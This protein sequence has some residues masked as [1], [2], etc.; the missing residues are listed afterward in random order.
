MAAERL[1]T[2]N[3][4]VAWAVA[5][6]GAEVVAA[7]PITPQTSIIETLAALVQK[8]VSR[9]E[10]VPVESEH[11]ALAACIGAAH[12]GAR[13]FTATSGQGLALMHELVH[14]AAG[15]RLP[16]VLADVNRAMAPGWSIWSDQNDSLSQ[17]DTGWIQLY[18]E[19]G[20][21]VLDSTVQAFALA[22][23]L[24]LPVMVVLDAFFLSHTAERVSV[25]DEAEVRDLI[26]AWDAP[27]RIDLD[28]PAARGGLVASAE[29]ESMRRQIAL[30]HREALSEIERTAAA[31]RQRFG[32]G[33]GLLD[34]YRCDGADE[35]LVASGTVASTGRAAIDALRSR[36]RAVGLVKVR[37]FRPFPVDALRAA[38]RPARRV[39]VLDRNCSYG[40]SGI[41]YQ[42]LRAALCGVAGAPE[43]HGFVAGMGG[44]DITP[45]TLVAAL[46]RAAREPPRPE[47]TW[48]TE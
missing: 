11:S 3:E 7:Y 38:L 32:R 48:L 13:T 17:R 30:A 20:Q 10:F 46:D 27:W 33:V 8:G 36:G 28:R 4:A 16:V 47:S 15:A 44:R 5:R 12:A 35:I 31:W 43:V 26:P 39:A 14:W 1:L 29:Y 9:A 25:P 34:A 6:A 41:F 45:G 22:A 40:A 18:C 24:S 23:R 21:E 19:E 2:G 42:E 37:C